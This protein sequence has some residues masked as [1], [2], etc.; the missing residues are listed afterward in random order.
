M[1]IKRFF[2]PDIRQAMRLVKEELGADAV[3]MSNR[4]VNNGVEIVAA[5]DFDEQVIHQKLQAQQERKQALLKKEQKIELPDFAVEKKKLHI[6]SSSRKYDI[7][8]NTPAQPRSRKLDQYISNTENPT[9]KREAIKSPAMKRKPLQQQLGESKIVSSAVAKQDDATSLLFE[10]RKELKSLRTAMEQKISGINLGPHVPLN[11]VRVDLLRRLSEMGLAKKL[12]IKIANRL[13]AHT[14]VDLAWDKAL[15]MLSGMLMQADDTLMENG[16][17]AALVGPTGVGKTTTIAKLAA[18]FILKHGAAQVALITTDTYR[19]AAYEQLNIYGRILDVP[20]RV[21]ANAEELHNLLHNFSDK[22][23][24][25]IDTAGMG[26]RDMRL[27]EQIKVL[28]QENIPIKSYLVMSAATQLTAMHEIINAFQKL[29]PEA[30]ILTKLDESAMKGPAL[31]ALIEH[32]LPL[33]Y[34]TDGQQVPEDLH[35]IHASELV[36]QCAA[37]L[38]LENDNEDLNY[39]DWVAQGYA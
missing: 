39:D 11:P 8:G 32:Q 18:K 14:D 9:L 3:I 12:G 10:M 22:R 13:G 16:G 33:A 21:A 26:Q 29:E 37:E 35:K 30:G 38:E 27:M 23:L 19:I 25:L 6:L 4:S 36:A 24:I 20:V 2:A 28:Q 5:M 34:V 1:K 15:Q 7:N 31:S 17:I